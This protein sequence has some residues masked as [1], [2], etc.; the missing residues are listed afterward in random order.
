M[1]LNIENALY[2]ELGMYGGKEERKSNKVK[3]KNLDREVRR[4]WEMC[5]LMICDGYVFK[6]GRGKVNVLIISVVEIEN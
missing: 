6:G 3:H 2:G 5:Q 4:G 1:E